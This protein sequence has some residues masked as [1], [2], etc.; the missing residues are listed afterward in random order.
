MPVP[1]PRQPLR[2]RMYGYPVASDIAL[3][4]RPAS[5][6]D[7]SPPAW[8]FR[9]AEAGTEPRP[10]GDVVGRHSWND[11]VFSELRRGPGGDWIWTRDSG[12]CHVS[13]DARVVV[14][15][16]EEIGDPLDLHLMLIGQI[17]VHVV[18]QLGHPVLHASAVV[19]EQGALGFLGDHGQGKST[20]AA[21]FVRRGATL[22]SDDALPLNVRDDGVW[23]RPGVAWMKV[24]PDTARQTLDRDDL[25]KLMPNH[26]KFDKR[27]LLLDKRY[28][29]AEHAARL[30]ALYVLHRYDPIASGRSDVTTRSLGLREAFHSL[31]AQTSWRALLEPREGAAMMPRYAALARQIPVR[32]LTYPDGYEFQEDVCAHV[33]ADVEAL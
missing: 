17:S 29:F 13:P 24:F 7:A 2:Y 5:N 4:L 26:E 19:C 12:T 32:V 33:L 15:Y 22:L 1:G 25:P 23:A 14:V 30:R 20:I 21:S 10:I 27:V 9:L 18:R 3:P 31:L 28:R 11:T 8:T 6:A 16:P